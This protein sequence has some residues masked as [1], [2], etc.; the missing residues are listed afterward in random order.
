ME[1]K[2]VCYGETKIWNS[3]QDAINFFADGIVCSEGSERERYVN[4][5]C[6]LLEGETYCTDEY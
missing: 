3:R 6:K 1:I 5:Y 4:I 2:T